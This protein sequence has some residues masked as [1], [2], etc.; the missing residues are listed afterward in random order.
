MSKCMKYAKHGWAMP[1]VLLVLLLLFTNG[2]LSI[3]FFFPV[4]NLTIV[5]V[6]F[7]GRAIEQWI[8][9]KWRDWRSLMANCY[10]KNV[11]YRTSIFICLSI[12][13]SACLPGCLSVC[14]FACLPACPPV[15]LSVCLSVCLPASLS[16]YTYGQ[17]LHL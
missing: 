7:S 13:L 6:P 12:C 1:F 3:V 8:K 11:Y 5:K 2:L 10:R 16:V 15:C 9:K 4:N 17:I 14:L